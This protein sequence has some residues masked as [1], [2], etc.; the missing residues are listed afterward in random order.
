MST[1]TSLDTALQSAPRLPFDIRNSRIIILSDQ[2]MGDAK[3]GSDD[4]LRNKDVYAAALAHY[5]DQGFH[6]VSLGD[7]EELWECDFSDV[8]SAYAGVYDRELQ[9]LQSGRLI[10]IHGNHDIFWRNSDFLDAFLRS[11]LPGITVPEAVLLECAEGSIFLAHG[12]QG[13]F[14]S[15]RFWRISRW[16]V[17]HFWKPFQ[18]LFRIPSTGAAQNIGERTRKE[19]AYYRWARERKLLFIAGHTHRAMFKSLSELDR[20]R[21][22]ISRA[23]QEMTS[24]APDSATYRQKSAEIAVLRNKLEEERK[25]QFPGQQEPA[26]EAA[27]TRTPCYFN[28][29]CCSYTSGIT[30]IEIDR[31]TIRLVKWD[32]KNNRRTVY[33][34]DSLR[35]IFKGI[36]H[37]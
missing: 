26:L 17:R 4:F 21:M 24:L 3:R 5:F 25:R 18:R 8:A 7:V 11:R 12:H 16:F 1:A 13:D 10:R 9:F 28:D 2:H 27:A 14:L 37:E 36:R 30:A 32:R 29:G 35:E 6:L 15:D 31:G 33:E 23:E 20:I 22:A 19:E 34:E